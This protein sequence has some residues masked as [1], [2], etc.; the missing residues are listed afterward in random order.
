[1]YGHFVDENRHRDYPFVFRSGINAGLPS[2]M[3]ADAHLTYQLRSAADNALAEMQ[4]ASIDRIGGVIHFNFQLQLPAIEGNELL[5]ASVVDI[6]VTRSLNL[7]FYTETDFT[8]TGVV[9]ISG[10][11]PQ[12]VKESLY[13]S[14]IFSQPDGNAPFDWNSFLPNGTRFFRVK[15]EPTCVTAVPGAG[16]FACS[17]GN[18]QRTRS[19]F[20]AGCPNETDGIEESPLD[21]GDETYSI[22]YWKQPFDATAD[23]DSRVITDELIILRA[24]LHCELLFNTQEN[25]ITIAATQ[26]KGMTLAGYENTLAASDKGRGIP[27]GFFVSSRGAIVQEHPPTERTRYDGALR[28][29]ETVRLLQQTPGKFLSLA[30]GRGISIESKETEHAVLI[31]AAGVGKHGC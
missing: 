13:G 31:T 16:V 8:D 23:D 20:P 17:V 2:W 19:M 9:E 26:G 5:P 1:M 15:L 11:A 24:G 22:D 28:P 6:K 10:D 14:L 21:Y 18:A 30:A 7:D 3:I 29:E 27:L 4:L 25:S 12:T